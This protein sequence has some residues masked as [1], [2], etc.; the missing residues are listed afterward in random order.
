LELI[1]IRHGQ[2]EHTLNMP[3]SLH[4]QDPALT[5][6][7]I[8]QA[9]L[10]RN[11]FLLSVTDLIV[12]SPIRRTLQTAMIWSEGIDCTKIITPLVSPRIFPF[13]KKSKTL[14]CDE[15]MRREVIKIEFAKYTLQEDL[16]SHLWDN[17][18]NTLL[19]QEFNLFAN[20]F[21]RWCKQQKKKRIYIV[22]HDGTNILS[23]NNF[24]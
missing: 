15:L 5:K 3:S 11:Q 1:F 19:E 24:G 6:E 7:G 22:S 21:L 17:G 4:I 9:Q 2:G 16:P 20:K 12:I 18:I 14:P 23:T 8:L 13:K 10:L